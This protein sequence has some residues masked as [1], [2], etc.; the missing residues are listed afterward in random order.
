MEAK[1]ASVW[2]IVA[3]AGRTDKGVSAFQQIYVQKKW[4]GRHVLQHSE[5]LELWASMSLLINYI[6][7]DMGSEPN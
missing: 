4:K 5:N 7:P 1:Y 2:A 3:I 6:A